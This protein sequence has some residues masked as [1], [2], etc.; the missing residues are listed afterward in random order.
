ML[1]IL[2][3]IR[4]SMSLSDTGSSSKASNRNQRI[5]MHSVKKTKINENRLFMDVLLLPP[6]Y[7]GCV[8]QLLGRLF[9]PFF[10]LVRIFILGAT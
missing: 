1:L 2:S 3:S 5:I 6:S 9:V 4:R 8:L 7:S 10:I